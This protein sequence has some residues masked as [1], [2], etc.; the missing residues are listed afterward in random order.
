MRTTYLVCYDIT[1]P[2]RLRRAFR[3]CKNYGLHLQYSVLECDLSPAERVSIETQ[4]FAEPFLGK[5]YKVV[6]KPLKRF[7]DGTIKANVDIELALDIMEMLDRLDVVC[8]VSGDG[9]FQRLVEVVQGKGVRVE[10]VAVGSSTAA[11]LRNAADHYIDLQSV[12]PKI[13]A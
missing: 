6:T 2:K 1:D 9:D 12:L 13:R 10:V 11:N 7:A 5:G 3:I 4:R 8:L